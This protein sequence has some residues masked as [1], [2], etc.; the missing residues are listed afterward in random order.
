MYLYGRKGLVTKDIGIH[1]AFGRN[2]VSSYPPIDSP[3]AFIRLYS[4][5]IV[6]NEAF[7]YVYLFMK[8][9]VL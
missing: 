6:V 2:Y 4:Y 3:R 1:T 8:S 7:W 9:G 5:F